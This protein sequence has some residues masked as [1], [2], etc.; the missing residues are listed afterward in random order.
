MEFI[1]LVGGKRKILFES[2][3]YV[4]QKNVYHGSARREEMLG[5]VGRK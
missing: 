2:H 5:R 3:V 4:K 1:N